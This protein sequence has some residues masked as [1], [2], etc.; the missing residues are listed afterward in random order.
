MCLSTQSSVEE[1][2]KDS[3]VFSV[4]K[5]VGSAFLGDWIFILHFSVW[6]VSNH[7][8][9]A[10]SVFICIDRSMWHK[11]LK[12][13]FC[14]TRKTDE[15]ISENVF[16][17]MDRCLVNHPLYVIV[18]CKADGLETCSSLLLGCSW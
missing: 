9:F 2:K 5:H 16:S 13:A 18:H 7:W 8:T 15:L 4:R 11:H 14:G 17:V 10:F 12:L 6:S 1:P 3:S